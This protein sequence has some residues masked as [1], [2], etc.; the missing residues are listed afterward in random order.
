MTD[1]LATAFRTRAAGSLRAHDAGTRVTLAGWVHRRR[2]L[3][4]LVFLD[5]RDREGIVQVSF[6]AAWSPEEV[7]AEARRL[8]PEDVVQVEGLVFPRI[9][10]QHNPDMATGDVEVRC[11]QMTVISRAEPLP[12][13]VYRAPNDELAAEELRLRYR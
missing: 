13:Q 2:D 4:S 3:G 11:E 8:G 5:L 12:I 1:V 10:G 9:Q 7:L 6:D